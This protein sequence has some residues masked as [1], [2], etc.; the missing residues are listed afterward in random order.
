[1]PPST[2]PA[3]CWF[4]DT[5]FHFVETVF[6]LQDSDIDLLA[7]A[8]GDARARKVFYDNAAC[9]LSAERS[10]EQR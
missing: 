8:T 5:H 4:F 9:V 1:M 2:L 3:R 6:A 10:S 7:D